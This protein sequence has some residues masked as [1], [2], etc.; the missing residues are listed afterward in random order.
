MPASPVP[1]WPAGHP[2]PY[3]VHLDPTW[4]QGR[5]LFGGVLAEAALRAMA[6]AA[7][8]GRP[9]RSAAVSFVSAAAPGPVQVLPRALRAG[10][11]LSHAAAEVVQDGQ[12]RATVLASFGEARTSPI[13]VAGPPPPPAPP[14]DAVPPFYPEGDDPAAQALRALI[15]AFV[16]HYD[17]R[18]T[19]PHF[20][21]LGG[22]TPHVQGW[23]RPRAAGPVDAFDLVALLDAWPA[24]VLSLARGPAPAS[25]VTW[26]LQLHPAAPPRGPWFFYE[27]RCT[28]AGDGYADL[29]AQLWDA[30]GALLASSTQL[31]AEF[32]GGGG[33][34]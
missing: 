2:G 14:P 3:E 10:A 27:A 28:A 34:R 20:P 23:V 15:P 13:R 6:A 18:W 5:A 29:Q 30:D 8:P 21:F 32:S 25:T 17:H 9:L 11:S 22:S 7:A 19:V 16:Q 33:G 12:L 26:H 24:P 1:A 31:V 4:G